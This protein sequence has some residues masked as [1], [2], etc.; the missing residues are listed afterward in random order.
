MLW[1]GVFDLGS[2]SERR[3]A[4]YSIVVHNPG[5]AHGVSIAE[6]R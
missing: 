5:G 4:C 2:G 1:F 6:N 3:E